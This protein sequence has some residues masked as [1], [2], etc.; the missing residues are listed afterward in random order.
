MLPFPA[1]VQVAPAEA[2][3]LQVAPCKAAGSV[4]VTLALGAWL[5]PVLVT[6]MV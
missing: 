4:S 5:G 6:R 1:A 2:E 3:Q